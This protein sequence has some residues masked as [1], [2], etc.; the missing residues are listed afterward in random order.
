MGTKCRHERSMTVAGW[1]GSCQFTSCLQADEVAANRPR[2]SLGTWMGVETGS[3]P[4]GAVSL[5]NMGLPALVTWDCCIHPTALV[6]DST[7]R[8]PG[9]HPQA[10]LKMRG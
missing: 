1:P 5:G 4:F 9:N 8:T 7:S 6:K 10:L 2:H 3:K